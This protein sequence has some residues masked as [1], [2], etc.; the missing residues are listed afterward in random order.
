ML[1]FPVYSHEARSSFRAVSQV[2][3]PGSPSRGMVRKIQRCS[4]VR[5][6]NPRTS[7]GGISLR[8]GMV[9][10]TMSPMSEPTT[11]TSLTTS[12]ADRHRKLSTVRSSYP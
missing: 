10:L 8:A 5:T 4:P 1:V 9:W 7:P 12:G 11:M 6:S 3:L 2:S